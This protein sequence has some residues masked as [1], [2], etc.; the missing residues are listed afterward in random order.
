VK[1]FGSYAEGNPTAKSDVDLLVEFKKPVGYFTVFGFQ[2]GLEKILKKKVEV[3]IAPLMVDSFLE[4]T[5]EVP[6]YDR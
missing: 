4:I 3:V 1:L 5:S 2:L 6:I